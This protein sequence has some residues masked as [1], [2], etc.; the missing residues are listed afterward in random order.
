M[1][2]FE[3]FGIPISLVLDEVELK[4]RYF[5]ISKKNHPDF[6]ASHDEEKQQEVLELSTLNTKAYQ[7]MNDFDKRMKYVLELKGKIIEGERYVLAPDFL[8]EMME[9]N[10]AIMEKNVDG[11]LSKVDGLL[12]EL[13]DE[14]KSEIENFTDESSTEEELN[15]I[16]DYY[17]KK[18]Y[19]LRIKESLDSFAAS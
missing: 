14:A 12:N 11:L 10:E 19:L 16:K 7:T 9:I 3:F 6:F 4:K 5:D 15:K 2:Y 1:N 18:K 17:Y 13:Y 8:M